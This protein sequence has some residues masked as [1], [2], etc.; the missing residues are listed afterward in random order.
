MSKKS[1]HTPVDWLL[2]HFNIQRTYYLLIV[3]PVHAG[4]KQ[5]NSFVS[6]Y[7]CSLDHHGPKFSSSKWWHSLLI[8]SILTQAHH[9]ED[10]NNIIMYIKI[11]G[12]QRKKNLAD[13]R[14]TNP[15]F[16]DSNTSAIPKIWTVWHTLRS[17]TC[18]YHDEWGVEMALPC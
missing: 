6:P 10:I 5:S 14:I 7:R 9:C 3:H 15:S 1:M 2:G 11:P 12:S 16:E 18:L 13:K 4:K 17:C 8:I